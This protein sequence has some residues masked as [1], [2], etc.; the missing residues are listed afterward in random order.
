MSQQ[1]NAKKPYL[2]IDCGA[3]VGRRIKRCPTCHKNAMKN[4]PGY[5]RTQEHRERMSKT[6]KGKSKLTGWHHSETTKQK[7]AAYYTPERRE[8]SK[9]RGQKMA[10]DREW[11]LRIAQALAGPNNPMWQGGIAEDGYAPGFSKTLKSHIRKRDGY[12]C[13]LCGATEDELCYRLSIHHA[14]YDKSNHDEYNLFAVCKRCNSLVN[15]NR[16]VWYG[17]FLTLA[18]NRQLGQDIDQFIG[19]KIISQHEGFIVSTHG[20]SSDEA[21]SI[22][23]LF[24]GIERN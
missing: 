24:S 19:R 10:E 18:E 3:P 9:Q 7:M 6:L 17:Y 23:D 4:R 8:I 16:L 2:C 14:D 20:M 11:R 12:K 13:Q 22:R 5:E 1:V 21:A 15:T